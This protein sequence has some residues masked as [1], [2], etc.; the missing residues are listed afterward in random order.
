MMTANPVESVTGKLDF[1]TPCTSDYECDDNEYGDDGDAD[2]DD[3]FFD[4]IEDA[5]SL[6]TDSYTKQQ[7]MDM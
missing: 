3:E 5:F 1:I 2:D 7:Q 4:A 6:L